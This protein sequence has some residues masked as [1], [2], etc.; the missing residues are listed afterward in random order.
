MEL[1]KENAIKEWRSFIGPTKVDKAKKEA[2]NSLRALFGN[3]GK[4]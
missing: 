4:K 1:I 2:P 3:G